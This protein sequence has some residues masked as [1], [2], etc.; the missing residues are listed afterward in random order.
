[1]ALKQPAISNQTSKMIQ[2]RNQ[3]NTNRSKHKLWRMLSLLDLRFTDPSIESKYHEYY[4]QVKRD[5]LPTAIQV[6][7][8]VNFLQFL[9]T[10]FN[11]YLVS[12]QDFAFG[13]LLSSSTNEKH[14][15]LAQSLSTSLPDR[16]FKND[17]N[18]K[19]AELSDAPE[20][21]QNRLKQQPISSTLWVPIMIQLLVFVLTLCL[22]RSIR[23]ELGPRH[24][25]PS[26]EPETIKLKC[27]RRR[28][29]ND[30]RDKDGGQTDYGDGDEEEEEEEEEEAKQLRRKSK[31]KS[32]RGMMLIR[33][34]CLKITNF[35]LVMPYILWLLQL[36]QIA[37]ALWPQQSFI[38][39]SILL[40]YSY[41][42]Y[43]ILPIRLPSCI[44]LATAMSLIEPC[45]DWLLLLKLNSINNA[46]V[47]KSFGRLQ[48]SSS[49]SSDSINSPIFNLTPSQNQSFAETSALV[50]KQNYFDTRAFSNNSYKLAATHQPRTNFLSNRNA[51]IE[52]VLSISMTSQI[53][54]LW[55]FMLLILG[56]NIIGIM[57]FFFYDRQ[58][59]S[60][61]IETRQ[62]FATKVT[63]EQESKEQE[64]L[65][66]SILPKHLA[67]EIRQDLGA[68]L[69][70]QFK[71]IYM[72]RHENV[73]IL[74]AD[75][76]GFTAISSH[77]PAP[78][79]VRTLNE[80]FARFDKLAEKYH[81]LRIKILG[82][83]YYAIS[84]APKER[85][86]HAVL[87]VHMGLSMVEA[88]KSVRERTKS[89]VDMRVGVHTG[90]VLAG[91]LGQRQ[92]QFDVYSKDVELANKMESSGLPGR[93]HI[94][95]ATLRFLND[96]FEV[97][98]GDGAKR[99]EALRLANI[100]TYFIVRVKKPVSTKI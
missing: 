91:V 54:K 93:V 14:S 53:T 40:L 21:G 60:A 2:R 26:S 69:T 87:C 78:E 55:A 95:N 61:F 22:L 98:D 29:S 38:A 49:I 24:R 7:L 81:Q 56:V 33:D 34:K 64:R 30:L 94:S 82:D 31:K 92:W 41:A 88:I 48:D 15:S 80:L 19:N 58:Q 6:V 79:L 97:C 1:M 8:L 57:S 96:E 86:D 25:R 12:G 47:T 28:L 99:E 4:A 52:S 11:Y 74:F 65:L 76:V 68:V 73:S 5:L 35:R 67:S 9:L 75:I 72:R 36:V 45:I 32:A 100:K 84:G 83:C 17:S 23:R 63:L 71:K 10:L 89:T 59:R 51:I 20:I 46:E 37:C 90:G 16:S 3:L 77:C 27:K 70:G 50:R 42:I 66:L 18:D 62:N 85:S 13:S 44:L 43:V 39:Y